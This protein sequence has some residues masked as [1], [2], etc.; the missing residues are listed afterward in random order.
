MLHCKNAA[1]L[2]AYPVAIHAE[3]SMDQAKPANWLD[4]GTKVFGSKETKDK[5]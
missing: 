4:M 3:C 2:L 5:A 1:D